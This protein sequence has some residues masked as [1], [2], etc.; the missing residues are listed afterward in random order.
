MK[1][2][3]IKT[4]LLLTLFVVMI[5]PSC[6]KQII[7]N[8]SAESTIENSLKSKIEVNV[9]NGII[10]FKNFGNYNSTIKKLLK[11]TDNERI[12]WSNSLSGFI[13]YDSA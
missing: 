1:K 6:K 4:G 2:L 12:N 5:L 13:S 7:N 10:V 3:F 11:L 9:E 8:L